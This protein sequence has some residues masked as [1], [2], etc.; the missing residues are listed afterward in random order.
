[1]DSAEWKDEGFFT[2][3]FLASG[4]DYES[5]HGVKAAVEAGVPV[6]DLMR[7]ETGVRRRVEKLAR[8]GAQVDVL[9]RALAA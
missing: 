3:R 8:E 6:K 5:V 9:V 7:A 2:R 4:V 1:M